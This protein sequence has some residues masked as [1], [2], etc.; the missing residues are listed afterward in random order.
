ML[1]RLSLHMAFPPCRAPEALALRAL[2]PIARTSYRISFLL[3]RE[4]SQ[5]SHLVKRGKLVGTI[6]QV[7]F[8]VHYRGALHARVYSLLVLPG[9]RALTSRLS[10]TRRTLEYAILHSP[11]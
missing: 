9:V 2:H 6:P 4:W 5:S 1:P 3:R 8:L 7:E 11:P 10:A